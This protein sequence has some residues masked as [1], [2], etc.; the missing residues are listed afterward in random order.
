MREWIAYLGEVIMVTAVSGLFYHIAP[1]GAM[2]KHLHFVISLCVLAALAVPMFSMVME[3]PEIFE[4]G[5]EDAEA[6]VP[7]T[8]EQWEQTLI[9]AGKRKVEA[10]IVSYISERW[11]IAPADITVETV[12]DTENPEAI[13]IREIRVRLRGSV[14]ADTAAAIRRELDE[15]F[16]GKSEITVSLEDL[17]ES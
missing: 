13:E 2:K 5:F 16:L 4:R 11:D 3:L 15:T 8:Q 7:A 12:L 10:G 14:S 6:E 9:D 1:E 17:E